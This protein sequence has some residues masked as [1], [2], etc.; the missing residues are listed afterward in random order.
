MTTQ[1]KIG[2]AIILVTAIAATIGVVVGVL[3]ITS[4]VG[5]AVI[6][7]LIGTGVTRGRF[8]TAPDATKKN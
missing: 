3:S 8:S 1:R 6:G 4:A 2:V 5:L 7:I